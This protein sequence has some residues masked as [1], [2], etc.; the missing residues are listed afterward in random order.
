MSSFISNFKKLRLYSFGFIGFFLLIGTTDV[1][2]FR[3]LDFYGLSSGFIFQFSELDKSFHSGDP[4]KITTAVF[5]DSMSI[6]AL[7]SDYLAEA[8]GRSKDTFYNFSIS[9][10]TDYDI[11][12]TYKKYKDELTNLK[13]VIVVVNEHQ[14]NSYKIE[15]DVK[16]KYYAGLKDRIRVMNWDNFGELL[17]G[18]VLKSYDLRTIWAKMYDSYREGKLKSVKPRAGG[19]TP[20]APDPTSPE[21]AKGKKPEVAKL[22]AERWFEGFDME[23]LQTESLE[24]LLKDLHDSGVR[25]IVLQI[26]RSQ[27]FEDAVKLKYA[28]EH[29]QYLAK[30]TE[31]A[32]KYGAEFNIMSNKGLSYEKHFRDPNHL[33]PQGARIVTARVAERWLK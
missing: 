13:E 15:N 24:L 17:I 14:L 19:L 5:G 25:I 7:R 26:P 23:G 20:Q 30:I 9:G 2:V 29:K 8:A 1:T 33:T 27:L 6:D 12:N 3:N 18:W 4:S 21:Y 16:F 28:S 11:Y 31:L 32:H 10:G 22:T